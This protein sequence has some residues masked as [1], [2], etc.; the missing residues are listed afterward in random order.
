MGLL[1]R[2]DI[3]SRFLHRQEGQC[4]EKEPQAVP[5]THRLL[6]A[7]MG[8]VKGVGTVTL[9]QR[10]ALSN[11]AA[12]MCLEGLKKTTHPDFI[13]TKLSKL[14]NLKSCS[15]SKGA[16]HYMVSL[17]AIFLLSQGYLPLLA[18]LRFPFHRQ[19]IR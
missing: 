17:K 13:R 9:T 4:L 1:H 19:A 5:V 18:V 14:G 16:P 3:T 10:G 11:P 7:F 2:L 15:P 8:L 12:I 6:T